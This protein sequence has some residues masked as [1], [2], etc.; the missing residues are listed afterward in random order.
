MHSSKL[1]VYKNFMERKGRLG[2]LGREKLHEGE[3]LIAYFGDESLI[4]ILQECGL[5]RGRSF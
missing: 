5:P 2:I 1:E 4:C 3:S